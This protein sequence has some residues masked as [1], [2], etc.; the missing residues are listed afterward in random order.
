MQALRTLLFTCCLL[1]FFTYVNAQSGWTRSYDGYFIQLSASTFSSDKFY[2][3]QGVENQLSDA[4]SSENLLIY[5]EYGV[6]ERATLLFNMPLV[7][8]Q[9]FEHTE[10][11]IGAGDIRL[12]FKYRLLSKLPVSVSIEAEIPT[13]SDELF[14]QYLDVSNT[15]DLINLPVSDAEYNYW[16]TLAASKS[17]GSGDFY[18]SLYTALNIRTKGYTNQLQVGAEVGKKFADKFWLIGKLKIQEPLAESDAGSTFFLFEEQTKYTQL[19]LTAFYDITDNVS[20]TGTYLGYSGILQGLQN[21][22]L[23]PTFIFGVAIQR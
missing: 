15:E 2:D 16:F 10:T 5:G 8:F 17:N 21:V 11:A 4:F 6:N 14:V 20:L 9:R 1:S 19:G 3:L 12:G 13:G 18:G 7:K 23:G 22:S